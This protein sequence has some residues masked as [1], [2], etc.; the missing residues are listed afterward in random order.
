MQLQKRPLTVAQILS[1]ADAHLARTGGWLGC[2]GGHVLDDKNEKWENVNQA[3]A[4]GYRG[5]PGGDSLARLLDRE[6]GRRN[7]G[8]L[9]D[10]T[11][12]QIVAWA[13][14]HRARTGEW[15]NENSGPVEG[16]RGE[17]WANVNQALRDGGRGLP[18]GDTLAGLLA[19][20]L[21]VRNLASTPRLTA[22]EILAW[23]DAHRGRAGKWP[24][25]GSGAIEG[26]P[27]ETWR[28]VDDALR[29]GLRGLPGGSSLARL[30]AERLG[31]GR[32]R[33]P[34]PG[35]SR[36][37]SP[38]LRPGLGLAVAGEHHLDEPHPRR[39]LGQP[40][41]AHR[42]AFRP[43]RHRVQFRARA[44]APLDGRPGTVIRAP[45][46]RERCRYLLHRTTERRQPHGSPPEPLAA[47]PRLAGPGCP[48]RGRG[49]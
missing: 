15:P 7:I 19:R 29:H 10:L 12:G 39:V 4:R 3:L 6:R 1:W 32:R 34:R 20:R 28:A 49:T 33:R 35:P 24:G 43:R 8:D 41:A 45:P 44:L 46:R 36:E 21:G 48:T 31:A 37:R 13:Q 22:E 23:A 17:V 25:V 42:T 38:R 16:T 18:G 14:E 27:G 47:I 11:E 26:A 40:P 9:P 2:E 30:L 5:L